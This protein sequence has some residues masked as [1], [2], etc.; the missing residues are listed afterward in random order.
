MVPPG[1]GDAVVTASAALMV[2]AKDCDTMALAVSVT[3]TVK[4]A[5]VALV[6]VPEM[7]PVDEF[8]ESPV[9]RDPDVRVHETY[10]VVPPL[11]TR[12]VL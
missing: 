1:S 9:G 12:V 8:S 6:G 4:L 7:T 11:A 10:G 3:L 2:K 5:V